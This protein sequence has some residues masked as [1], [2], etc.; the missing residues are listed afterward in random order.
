M[1]L[2][3]KLVYKL[4]SALL[5]TSFALS[6]NATP[7]SSDDNTKVLRKSAPTMLVVTGHTFAKKAEPQMTTESAVSVSE[8]QPLFLLMISLLMLFSIRKLSSKK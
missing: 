7:I 5:I 4:V 3:N 2:R 1:F 8:P 6:V